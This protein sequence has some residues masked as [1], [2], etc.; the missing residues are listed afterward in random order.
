[1]KK[2]KFRLDTVLK[3]KKI[4]KDKQLAQYNRA[5]EAFNDVQNQI[6]HL[7]QEQENV[8]SSMV[9]SAQEGFNLN[10]HQ[11]YE[12]YNQKIVHQKNLEK[13]RLG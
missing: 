2:F 12:F 3:Y 11:G 9:Q 13:V 5:L 4:L 1:M 6:N 8:F 10:Q 7:D